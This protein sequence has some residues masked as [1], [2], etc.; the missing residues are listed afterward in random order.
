MDK[1]LFRDLVKKKLVDTFGY[2][3]FIAEGRRS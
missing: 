2:E 3:D 1:Q